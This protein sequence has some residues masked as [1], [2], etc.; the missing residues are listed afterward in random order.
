MMCG[1]SRPVL[2]VFPF[3]GECRAA[4]SLHGSPLPSN[5][6][7][8]LLGGAAGC[9][10]TTQSTDCW[11]TCQGMSHSATRGAWVLLI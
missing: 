1:T 2:R 8:R 7:K 6:S 9:F 11:G 3:V 10:V 5:D 4:G